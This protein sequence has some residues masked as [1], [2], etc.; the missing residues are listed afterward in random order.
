MVVAVAGK[1]KSGV[2]VAR[3]MVSIS[4]AFKPAFWIANF[5]A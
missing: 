3:I 1:V 4:S 2:V 5:A